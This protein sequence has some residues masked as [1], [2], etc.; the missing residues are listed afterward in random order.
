MVLEFPAFVLQ[1]DAK[2]RANPD[3]SFPETEFF[4]GIT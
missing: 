3:G 1:D 4:M 2:G